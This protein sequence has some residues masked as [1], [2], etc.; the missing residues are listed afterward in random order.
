M[1]PGKVLKKESSGFSTRK[2]RALSNHSAVKREQIIFTLEIMNADK[3]AM[4]ICVLI[5]RI[6]NKDLVY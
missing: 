4:Q 5:A 1:R 2:C 3:I 6:M